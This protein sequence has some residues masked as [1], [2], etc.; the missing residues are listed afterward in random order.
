MRAT[1]SNVTKVFIQILSC[2]V[3]R[4]SE[5]RQNRLT[6]TSPETV[7]ILFNTFIK[8]TKFSITGFISIDIS[9]ICL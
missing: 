4:F 7:F 3:D 9:S 2:R 8:L 1:S 6:V 5:G